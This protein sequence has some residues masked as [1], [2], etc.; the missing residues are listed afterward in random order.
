MTMKN[1]K[2]CESILDEPRAILDPSVWQEPSEGGKPILT[3][4]AASK[5]HKAIVWA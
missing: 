5:L 3:D 2:T 1:S 4:E